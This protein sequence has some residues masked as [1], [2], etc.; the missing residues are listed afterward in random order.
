[1]STPET[2]T[3]Q[4]VDIADRVR[5][6]AASDPERVA[7]VHARGLRPRDAG[8]RLEQCAAELVGAERA[9]AALETVSRADL[10][11]MKRLGFSDAQHSVSHH[12]NGAGVHLGGLAGRRSVGDHA[13]AVA[14]GVEIGE[15]GVPV[16]GGTNLPD[17]DRAGSRAIAF[18]QARAV[19]A[20]YVQDMALA[21]WEQPVGHW[22]DARAGFYV[23]GSR[24][25]GS[26]GP[27]FASFAADSS[28][29]AWV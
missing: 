24:R 20:A 15:G 6:I 8:G 4:V 11:R 2:A 29:S 17:H 9:Y 26:M 1:M 12:G 14:D 25:H 10:L 21:D 16:P 27:T 19:R 3:G 7:L 13:V 5:A 22:F 28:S 18:P 23:V